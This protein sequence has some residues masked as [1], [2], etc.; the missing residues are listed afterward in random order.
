MKMEVLVKCA[1][2]AVFSALT[3]LLLRR[4]NP[5]LSFAL[6]TAAVAVILLAGGTLLG[7]LLGVIQETERI[8]GSVSMQMRPVLKCL[9]I[10]AASKY[11]ADL[12]RDASQTAIASALELVGGL[13]AAA[14]AL[15]TILGL[16]TTI[17]GML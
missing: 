10:A 11:G 8:F 17:G 1:A 2:L 12:C 4:F 3:G 9:G 15:P 16:M 6:S 5:E 14:T 13:C 7:K